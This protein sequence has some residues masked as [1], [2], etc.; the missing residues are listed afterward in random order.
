[1]VYVPVPRAQK[2]ELT[3]VAGSLPAATYYAAV[4]WVGSAGAEGAP[5]ELAAITLPAGKS[6]SV[7]PVNPPDN[8]AGWNVYVGYSGTDSS[9]QN[10]SSLG[11]DQAW[12][13]P[14]SG[15]KKGKATGSGQAPDTYLRQAVRRVF[16]RG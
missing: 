4:T 1:V 10:D 5:S 2:P 14:A 16:D 15:L 12:V 6:L 11:P 9:L 3:V 7:K 13:E 8:A